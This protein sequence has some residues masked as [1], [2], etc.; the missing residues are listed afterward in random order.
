MTNYK[1]EFTETKK[2]VIEYEVSSFDK[3][4]VA[5]SEL[6]FY[7]EVPNGDIVIKSRFPEELELWGIDSL[8]Y[9]DLKSACLVLFTDGHQETESLRLMTLGELIELVEFIKN[10]ASFPQDI[11]FDEFH[12]RSYRDADELLATYQVCLIPEGLITYSYKQK[13]FLNIGRFIGIDQI[14]MKEEKDES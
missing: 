11:H 14:E 3:L 10:K 9:Y 4:R 13:L 6:R 7:S 5:A 1:F 8:E 2:K 12:C